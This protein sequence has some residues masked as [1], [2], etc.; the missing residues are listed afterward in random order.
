M[1]SFNVTQSGNSAK[2]TTSDEEIHIE[3][4]GRDPR[5]VRELVR[6]VKKASG[7]VSDPWNPGKGSISNS[8]WNIEATRALSGSLLKL[9]DRFRAT[10][11]QGFI[12]QLGNVFYGLR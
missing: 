3:R 6:Q 2:K 7:G 12:D 4:K 9:T 10:Y 5:A 11:N 8:F 1:T